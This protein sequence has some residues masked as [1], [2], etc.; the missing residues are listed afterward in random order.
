MEVRNRSLTFQKIDFFEINR[1]RSR[2]SPPIKMIETIARR[3][4]FD[5]AQAPHDHG[6]SR[7]PIFPEPPVDIQIVLGH[8]VDIL[9][10]RRVKVDV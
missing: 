3:A 10:G 2:S 5:R 7:T 8:T 6:S 1:R 4:G 9:E